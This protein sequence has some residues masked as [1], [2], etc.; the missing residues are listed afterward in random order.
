[1]GAGELEATWVRKEK[2]GVLALQAAEHVNGASACAAKSSGGRK[3][4]VRDRESIAA[5]VIAPPSCRCRPSEPLRSLRY[6]AMRV[7]PSF[8]H[9]P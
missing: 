5:S 6:A 1:V 7:P 3:G 9:S 2:L 4:R 8:S